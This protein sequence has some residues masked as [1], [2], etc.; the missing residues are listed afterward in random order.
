MKARKAILFCTVAPMAATAPVSVFAQD[1]VLEEILV[2][3]QRREQSLAD[4]PASVTALSAERV[5]DFLAAGENIRA[6][7][8]RAPSLSVESSNGRQSPRFYIRGIGNYDFDV[9]ATQPVSMIMDEVVLENSVLKSFPLFDV[10]QVEV[11]AGPQA[12]LFGRSTTAGV[13]KIDTVKP[14]F[15]RDGYVNASYGSRETAS[16]SGAF[17]GGV[18]DTVA[19]RASFNFLDRGDW[20][21]NLA[22]GNEAGGFDEFSYRLQMLV[23]PTEDLSALFKLHGFHQE[24]NQPQ[25]FY[26]NAFT[27]GVSGLRPGFDED[28]YSHD[29]PAGFKLDHIGGS[30]RIEYDLGAMTLTSI[31]AYDTLENFSQGDI[32][33]GLQG[34]PEAIGVPG[35]QAFFSVAS[36]DGLSD[37]GQF[38]QEFRL[39]GESDNLF[40]QFGLYYFDEDITVDSSDIA[41]DG[42]FINLTQ[43]EQSTESIALFG[44]MVFDLSDQLAL[45]VGGRY[46]DDKK[47]LQVIPGFNSAAPAATI[48]VEDDYFNGELALN[49]AVNDSLNIF[50]RVASASRGPVTLGRFGFTSRADTETIVSYEAGFKSTFL[51]GRARLNATVYSWEMDDQQLTATGG[52][53][54]TNEV[55][56][57]DTEG[58][59]IELDAEVLLTD[60]LRL[61][62]NASYNDTE[63]TDSGL[64]TELCSTTP[65]CTSLD[66]IVDTFAGNFGTVNLVSVNGN[67]LP[68][69]PDL[70]SNIILDYEREINIGR[71]Y[72]STD[73]S[74]RSEN[75]IFLYES[76]EF[77]SEARWLGG[78]R[79]G[80]EMDNGLDI[81]LVGRNITNEITAEGAIDFLN[82]T[83]FINEPSFWGIELRQDF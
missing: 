28:V 46:T 61:T 20:L 72:A 62:F 15:E 43:A 60:N 38:V 40:Y 80:V 75:S 68:R 4:I 50:G 7:A 69:A 8:A 71:F 13:V 6:L 18:S 83:A 33:G 77:N 24:G 79:V 3:A 22:N 59:G 78:L 44:Q 56:N 16:L 51:D 35:R 42:T 23:E 17:G 63:I 31:T 54:N 66:P 12:T 1:S 53:G 49:Y 5:D 70:I 64:L 10:Q 34:G 39:S 26:A 65:L 21:D 47:D 37:H 45:T 27:P 76:V 82:P 32:D 11:L 73:W 58:A 25:V 74:Y 19:V 41:N 81:S 55:L 48:S 57:A 2:T 29:A 67:D 52:T 36:G 14:T 30:A 9:N